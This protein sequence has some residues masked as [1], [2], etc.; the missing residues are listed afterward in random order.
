MNITQALE[1]MK[2]NPMTIA[3]LKVSFRVQALKYHP[4][5]NPHGLEM[6]KIINA[7]NV[8][9][10]E[11]SKYWA[12]GSEERKKQFYKDHTNPSITEEMDEVLDILRKFK[13]ITVEII[14]TWI[15][16]SGTTEPYKDTLK[17]MGFWHSPKR[18]AYYWKPADWKPVD[19]KGK[20]YTMEDLRK[21]F[22]T[23]K[24]KTDPDEDIKL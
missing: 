23:E 19:K 16:V 20:D 12:F 11:Q 8:L 21:I 9:L 4:D 1:I 3:G 15:W 5:R 14:G 24:F 18:D 2:P 22:Y 7:A 10:Q 6:M 13:D 17:H